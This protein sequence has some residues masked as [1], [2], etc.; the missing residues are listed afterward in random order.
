MRI[1][2]KALAASGAAILAL[3]I[4]G[5]TSSTPGGSSTQG[6][7][8]VPADGGEVVIYSAE[9]AIDEFA[10]RFKEEHPEITVQ[11]MHGSSGEILARTQAEAGSPQGD[12]WW[13]GGD[14]SKSHPE[15]F[16]EYISPSAADIDPIFESA[17]GMQSPNNAFFSTFVYNKNL[18]SEDEVPRTWA[19]L[20]DPKWKGKI[21]IANPTAS[22]AA[23]LAMVNWVEVG[24]WELVEAIAPNLVITESSQAP[25][26][27]TV[28]GEAHIGIVNEV[29]AFLFWGPDH[30]D[31]QYPEDGVMWALS[32]L[33]LID[34]GPNTENGKKFID[35]ML[36]QQTQQFMADEFDGMRPTNSKAVL[37]DMLPIDELNVLDYPQDATDD[38]EEWLAKWR[39]IITSI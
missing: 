33:Y 34:N 26:K 22:S 31:V 6:S 36:S 29:G 12:V 23:Y 32:S 9:A 38:K 15:L 2:R 39:D 17:L 4:A 11:V 19:D 10:A 35:W 25:A 7:G 21:H 14:V 16:A 24:G 18:V 27:N 1:S 5:C 8:D 37:S 28:D 13:G 20:A 3:S 30:L